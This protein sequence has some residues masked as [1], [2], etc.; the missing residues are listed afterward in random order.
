[1]EKTIEKRE[2]VPRVVGL[3]AERR[4]HAIGRLLRL[5]REKE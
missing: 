1:L 5:G 3:W 2:N 4:K